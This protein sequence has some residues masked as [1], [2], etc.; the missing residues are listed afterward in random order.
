MDFA[1]H[2]VIIYLIFLATAPSKA[3]KA[4]DPLIRG[5]KRKITHKSVENWEIENIG[6]H[7]K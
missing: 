5:N 1:A 6:K 2:Y 7:S 4:M 3:I